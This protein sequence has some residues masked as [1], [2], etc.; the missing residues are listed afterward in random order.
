[1]ISIYVVLAVGVL[2]TVQAETAIQPGSQS[3]AVS[4]YVPAPNIIDRA[5]LEA[6]CSG[7]G[8]QYVLAFATG[9]HLRQVSWELHGSATQNFVPSAMSKTV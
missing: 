3:K 7:A 8:T 1:M 5:A 2:V 4:D 9:Q 6:T